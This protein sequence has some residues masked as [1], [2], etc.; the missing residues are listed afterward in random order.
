MLNALTN[1]RF[2][3]QS[4][5]G[6][7]AAYQTRFMSTRP[8]ERTPPCERYPGLGYRGWAL[9]LTPDVAELHDRTREKAAGG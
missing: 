2:W 5:H 9:D 8:R 7:T 6:P 1:V 4:G 3:G